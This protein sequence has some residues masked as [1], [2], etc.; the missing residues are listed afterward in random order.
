MIVEDYQMGFFKSHDYTMNLLEA[1]RIEKLLVQIH[2]TWYGLL[3]VP[4]VLISLASLS[5]KWV[6]SFLWD[7]S[8][9]QAGYFMAGQTILIFGC[10][11]WEMPPELKGN[12]GDLIFWAINGIPIA[13]SILQVVLLSPYRRFNSCLVKCDFD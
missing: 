10:L 9:I 8:V 6:P 3:L 11:H 2:V 4:S 1:G 13:A 12:A 7:L 5:G